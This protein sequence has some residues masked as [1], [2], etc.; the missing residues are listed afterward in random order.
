MTWLSLLLALTGTFGFFCYRREIPKSVSAMVFGYPRKLQWLWS[1]W[2]IAVGGLLLVPMMERL[3]DRLCCFGF[4]AFAF[5]VGAAVTPLVNRE[6]SLWHDWLGVSAGLMSQCVVA[7]LNPVWLIWWGL[8]L[9]V[10]PFPCM[11]S[12]LVLVSEVCCA[13]TLYGVLI[14]DH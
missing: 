6:T 2:L 7:I 8:Y 12:R 13:A 14:I 4:L 3:D 1:A 11:R 5:L 10:L 9:A